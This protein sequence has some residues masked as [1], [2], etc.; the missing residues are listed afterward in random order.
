MYY[1]N[2]N[3]SKSNGAVCNE[4]CVEGVEVRNLLH[5][6]DEYGNAS[7]EDDEDDA[8][9]RRVEALVVLEFGAQV[10]LDL[11]REI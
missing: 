4:T 11:K 2:I 9:D 5:V 7:H 10:G 6:W 1:I 3:V 8:D